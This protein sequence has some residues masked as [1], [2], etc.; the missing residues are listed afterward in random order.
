MRASDGQEDPRVDAVMLVAHDIHCR[1]KC[2]TGRTLV[3]AP[4]WVSADA[5]LLSATAP[6]VRPGGRS[7]ASANAQE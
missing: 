6:L 4:R 5:S 1:P 2:E 3:R 7:Q